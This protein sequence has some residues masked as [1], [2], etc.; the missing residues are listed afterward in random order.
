MK[1]GHGGGLGALRFGG[2]G[3]VS[4]DD[5]TYGVSTVSGGGGG[6]FQHRH[7]AVPLASTTNNNDD[8]WGWE[9]GNSGGEIELGNATDGGDFTNDIDEDDLQKAL[10]LSLSDNVGRTI[11][12]RSSSNTS[13]KKG[14]GNSINIGVGNSASRQRKGSSGSNSSSSRQHRQ[15]Q[16]TTPKMKNSW[17]DVSGWDVDSPNTTLPKPPR[18]TATAVPTSVTNEV[19]AMLAANNAAGT[20]AITSLGTKTKRPVAPVKKKEEAEDIFA[21]M[22]LSSMSGSGRVPGLPPAAVRPV[23]SLAKGASVPLSSAWKSSNRTAQIALKDDGNEG[24]SVGGSD[25]DDDL[26]DLLDD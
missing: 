20:T 5:F 1:A 14:S 9:D 16:R 25:W 6:V 7:E 3:G 17:D 21:A 18:P 24:D 4:D 13:S 10:D 8:E 22:G 19:E 23:V 12:N 11:L 15:P 26:D 2:A